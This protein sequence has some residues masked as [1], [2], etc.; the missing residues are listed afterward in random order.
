MPFA[1]TVKGVAQETVGAAEARVP[2][3][4]R[5]AAGLGA[6]SGE[7]IAE[8]VGALGGGIRFGVTMR[9]S[10]SAIGAGWGCGARDVHVWRA[11]IAAA[12]KT[13]SAATAMTLS[14][15]HPRAA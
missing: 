4:D 7:G 11:T 13:A 8:A 5:G 10:R 1:S 9:V 15:H 2:R 3:I 14:R 12:A 6:R